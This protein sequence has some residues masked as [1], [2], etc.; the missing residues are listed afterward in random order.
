MWQQ[1][2]SALSQ[3][4]HRVL[5]KLASFLPGLVALLLAV[6]LLTLIG[7][8]PRRLACAASSLPL[9]LMSA[10]PAATP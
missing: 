1:V 9:S 10:S 8:A 4:A 7:A 5:F 6:L 2:H 3:S